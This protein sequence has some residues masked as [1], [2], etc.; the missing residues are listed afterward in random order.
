M[1]LL[2]CCLTEGW[3]RASLHLSA[4]A[5]HFGPKLVNVCQLSFISH[6]RS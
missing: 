2:C 4:Q 3:H 1:M 6:L 5:D